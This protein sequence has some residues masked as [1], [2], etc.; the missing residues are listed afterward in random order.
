MTD[1]R[2]G[3]AA[4][5]DHGPAPA[6]TG[7]LAVLALPGALRT[8]LPALLGRLSFAM[9][10]LGLL[11]LVQ[12]AT[13]SFAAA[14]LASGAFGLAN[15][16]A[17][18]ARARLVDARGQRPVLVALALGHAPGL[19][20]LLAVVRA[21]APVGIVV[22]VA[23]ASPASRCRR[24]APRCASSGR[25]SCPTPACGRA[26]TASTPSARRSSSPSVRCW[27]RRSSRSRIPSW[28]CSHRPPR[29]CSARSA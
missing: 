20:A 16:L 28:P 12:S 3:V 5:D 24:S 18:P 10:T 4:T 29:R 17:S 27:S 13:G 22:A 1:A 25:R 2:P 14:G 21:D 7:Y 26:P 8:F 19:V 9:V 11:L 6:R 23:G 15:V